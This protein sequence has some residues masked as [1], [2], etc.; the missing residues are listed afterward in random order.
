METSSAATFPKICPNRCP[1]HGMRILGLLRSG[2]VLG[3]ADSSGQPFG[4][5]RGGVHLPVA[6]N[7]LL[8]DA[9]HHHEATA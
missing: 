1:E 2:V 6:D 8:L 3:I 9:V 4:I 5:G 7:G